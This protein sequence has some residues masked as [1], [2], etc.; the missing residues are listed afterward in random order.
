MEWLTNLGY[1]GLFLGTFLSGTIVPLNS[2]LILVALLALGGNPWLCMI[3]ATVGNWSGV[4]TSYL[5]GWLGKWEW[6]QKYFNVKLEKIEKQKKYIEKYGVWIALLPFIPILGIV[7]I[8]ALGFYKIK[9]KTTALLVL[10][11]CVVR[12]LLWTILY[13][14]F[15]DQF[16]DW[17]KNV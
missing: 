8:I 3:I 13:I 16:I 7:G 10:I 14:K 5:F 17:I 6:L 11:A 4:M 15:G 12:F 9:P 1:L 2:D